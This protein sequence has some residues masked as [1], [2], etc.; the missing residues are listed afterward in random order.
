MMIE[1]VLQIAGAIFALIGIV[2][3][4]SVWGII[5]WRMVVSCIRVREDNEKKGKK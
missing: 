5:A 1:A 2:A 4:I 3:L